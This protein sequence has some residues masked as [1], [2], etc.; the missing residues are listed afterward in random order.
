MSIGAGGNRGWHFTLDAG[1]RN[2]VQVGD[3]GRDVWRL[4]L[5]TSALED[6][7]FVVNAGRGQIALPGAQI[8]NLDLTTNAGQTSVDLTEAAVA[9]VSSTVNAGMLSFRLPATADLTGSM[10]VNAGELQMCVPSGLG[11]R[12]HHTGVLSGISVNGLHQSGTDWESPDYAS[13]AH[14]AD[15]NVIVNLGNVEIDPIGGCK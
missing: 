1:G 6:V 9:T 8:G 15:L 10:K 13:A 14:H 2:D 7:S 3:R 5:P 12:V 11:V 4:T